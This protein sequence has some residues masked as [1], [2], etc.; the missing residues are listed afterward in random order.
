MVSLRGCFLY[1]DEIH[2]VCICIYI[3]T[4]Y[5]YSHVRMH[6]CCAYIVVYFEKR[7]H[8]RSGVRRNVGTSR[9]SFHKRNGSRFIKVNFY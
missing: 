6:L 4:M 3:C 5:I 2:I 1:F 7:N 8:W 9:V